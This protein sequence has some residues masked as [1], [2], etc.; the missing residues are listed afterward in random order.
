MFSPTLNIRQKRVLSILGLFLLLTLSGCLG[1]GD[2]SLYESDDWQSEVLLAQECGLKD[3]PCCQDIDPACQFELR[4]CVDPNNPKNTFCSDNCTCGE[5]NNY[6]CTDDTPCQAGM[7]CVDSRCQTCGETDQPC[8]PGEP[9][10]KGE[11]VCRQGQCVECGL[12]GNPCCPNGKECTGQDLKGTGRTECLE[13]I[14]VFCGANGGIAC[15][16]DPKCSARHILNNNFCLRCGNV[17]QP[18]CNP[19]ASG[20]DY[21]CNENQGLVCELGFCSKPQQF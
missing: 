9:K 2:G 13:G 5:L 15:Q 10:C 20:V 6:C 18:C 12:S 7:A 8:C 3:L 21:E 4:C 16:N 19:E 1:L 11:L 17:N 14:C